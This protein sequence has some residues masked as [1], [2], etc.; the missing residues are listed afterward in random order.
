LAIVLGA[1]RGIQTDDI[2]QSGGKSL[3][4]GFVAQSQLN[5]AGVRRDPYLLFRGGME[6]FWPLC[7]LWLASALL[8][9]IM[10]LAVRQ[11]WVFHDELFYWQM[12][13]SFH[14]SGRF[15]FFG[16]P[17]DL[18]SRL[19]S[20]LLSFAFALKEPGTVFFCAKVINSLLFSAAIFPAF[21]L[22][23]EFLGRR[24]ALSVAI[25]SVMLSSGVYTAT[26]QPENLY[27]P[28]F[29]LA[30]WMCYRAIVNGTF[31]SAIAAGTALVFAYF[32]KPHILFLAFAY[33][34]VAA[35]ALWSKWRES[36]AEATKR[37]T[38]SSGAL[39]YL[40]PLLILASAL[41][42]KA[43]W[44]SPAEGSWMARI[45]GGVYASSLT[46]GG[47]PP[48]SWV[49]FWQS[50]VV[51]LAVFGFGVAAMPLGAPFCVL[52]SR[53]GFEERHRIFAWLVLAS[54]LICLAVVSRHNT[55]WEPVRA[56]E[57]YVFVFAPGFIICAAL[58]W[59]R[60]GRIAFLVSGILSAA[61]V[62]SS[63]LGLHSPIV[64]WNAPED[65]PSIA[66]FFWWLQSGK[67]AESSTVVALSTLALIIIWL[68][69]LLRRGLLVTS[70]SMGIFLVSLNMGWLGSQAR[71]I[72][73]E[74]D[75]F[76]QLSQA[77]SASLRPTGPVAVI[78]DGLDTRVIWYSNFWLKVPVW[79]VSVR[80]STPPWW[81]TKIVQAPDGH[82][83][84]LGGVPEYVV[85]AALENLPY[86]CVLTYPYP[87]V[88]VYRYTSGK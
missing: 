56:Y 37:K 8:R 50:F 48:F 67:T 18:P 76:T 73:P 9:T 7:A 12:A 30:I 51:I 86:D 40:L 22:A 49:H 5:I 42:L 32:V 16:A 75:R 87:A 20:V 24:Q 46:P 80:S 57:R 11:P 21:G 54:F 27:Y 81:G 36:C 58:A 44:L 63:F 60:A 28:A 1:G 41:L 19:Y 69:C 2:Q 64:N 84:F 26:I 70:A 66:G 53:G 3:L 52:S 45:V 38:F 78:S 61:F 6:T 65:S 74:T 43:L 59:R 79:T 29:I 85:C 10:G 33:L 47:L 23:K 71:L 82:L 15:L 34:P 35:L 77:I 13:Q 31:L 14:E 55:L 25:L 62:V 68:L 72:Q 83:V 39:P 88:R 17:F 4:C